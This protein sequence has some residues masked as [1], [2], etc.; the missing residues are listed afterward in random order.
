MEKLENHILKKVLVNLDFL[1]IE[2]SAANGH[3]SSRYHFLL[4]MPP[5]HKKTSNW[6]II[7]SFQQVILFRCGYFYCFIR[8][9]F[10][11]SLSLINGRD[12]QAMFSDGENILGG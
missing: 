10:D 7:S 9:V 12:G 5:G 4:G 8:Q 2:A 11:R 3:G 6:A 1:G